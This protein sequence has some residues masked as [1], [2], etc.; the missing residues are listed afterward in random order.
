MNIP[1]LSSAVAIW[2]PSAV[3]RNWPGVAVAIVIALSATFISSNY[4]GP[5]LLYAL[6]FGLAF[7]FLAADKTWQPGIEFCSKILLRAGVALLGA[8]ITLTQ[9]RIGRR[10]AAGNRDR[11]AIGD[12]GVWLSV[13]QV[14]KTS[15]G[16]RHSFRRLCSNLR[17]LRCIGN[18]GSS[19]ADQGNRAARPM[20]SARSASGRQDRNRPCNRRRLA[21]P[22]ARR[23]FRHTLSQ[24]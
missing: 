9:D 22:N 24:H 3:R 10:N 21:G 18:F 15:G 12:L 6:F 13:G 11:R 4:G 19:S 7:Q 16:G 20:A 2:R 8:R 23:R 5:Q 1:Y 14:A 17:C